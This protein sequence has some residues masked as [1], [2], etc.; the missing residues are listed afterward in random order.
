MTTNIV[1]NT[2]PCVLIGSYRFSQPGKYVMK[3]TIYDILFNPVNPDLAVF[4]IT[5][6]GLRR[7]S[8]RM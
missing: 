6:I 8:T 7:S 5:V 2:G 3:V 1:I 4:N